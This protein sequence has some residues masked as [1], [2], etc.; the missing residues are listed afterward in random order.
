MTYSSILFL[1]S[2]EQRSGRSS[3]ALDGV[4]LAFSFPRILQQ[5]LVVPVCCACVEELPVRPQNARETQYHST[6]ALE[7]QVSLFIL[8]LYLKIILDS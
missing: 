2:D 4:R 1:D 8:Y 7:N 5:R 3:S 6:E